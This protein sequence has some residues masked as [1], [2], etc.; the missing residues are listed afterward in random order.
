MNVKPLFHQ[1]FAPDRGERVA[2]MYEGREI[3][4]EELREMTVRAAEA[5]QALA[6]G[7]RDRV[8]ILLAD[9]PEFISSFVAT[10]SLGAIAV[11]INMALSKH[12]QLFILKDCGAR[13]AIIEAQTV[14]SLFH[15]P[16]DAHTPATRHA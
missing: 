12:D 3:T 8:A 7:S 5:I 16:H 6:V 13:V 2:V 11:P 14:E 15:D 9:S 4:Y 10:I 1:V